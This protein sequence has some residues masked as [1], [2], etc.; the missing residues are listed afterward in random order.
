MRLEPKID[1]GAEPPCSGAEPRDAGERTATIDRLFQEHNRVLVNFLKARLQSDA[2]AREVAQ[3][4]YVRLLQLDRPGAVGFLRAY[5]FRIAANL[6]TDRLRARTVRERVFLQDAGL[7]S[8]WSEPS[9]EHRVLAWQELE[10]VQKSLPELPAKCRKVF[11]MHVFDGLST[12]QVGAK[13][14]ITRRMARLY[15]VR[16]LVHLRSKLDRDSEE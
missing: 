12:E 5:L 8:L 3:E 10:L 7:A 11:E 6:A 9:P 16:A 1:P 2:E 13:L 14:G 4:A 15:V